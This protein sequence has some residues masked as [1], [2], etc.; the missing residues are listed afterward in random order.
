MISGVVAI[1]GRPNVGKSTIFNRFA[2]ERIS[3]VEDSPGVTRDRIYTTIEWLTRKFNLI[4][5]GGIQLEEDDFQA[6]IFMQV[7]IAIDEADTIVFVVD[8]LSGLTRDDEYIAGLLRKSGKHIILAVNKIDDIEHLNNIYEFY[9]LGLGEPM[10][11]SGEHGVGVGDVLDE[12]VKSLE[13]K[14]IYSKED[15]IKFAVIGRPNVGKST[16]VNKML[17]EQRVIVSD[18]EGTTRDAIDTSFKDEDGNDYVVVD[19]AGIRKRGKVYENIE[20]YSVLRAMTAIDKAD[21]IVFLIDGE[22]GIIEQDKHV[23]GYA[24]DAGKPIL[25][26]YNKWDA[27]ASEEKDIVAM[28]EKIRNEFVYLRYAPIVFI[29]SMTGQR[30]NRILP[31]VKELYENSRRRIQTSVLNEVILDAQ[32]MTPAPI[33]DGRRLRIYYATQVS[34]VPPTFVLFVNDEKLLHFSYK[35]YLENRLREAFIFDGTPIRVIA[36]KRGD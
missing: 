36:R 10:A 20:K 17:N 16:L 27:V 35:R 24:H 33:H 29:S 18:I 11:I 34:I 4:D 6:E 30:V 32:M 2:G 7:E 21:V 13:G 5:T 3:I 1:V 12:V 15:A 8:G 25:I 9:N 19:T 31:L 14:E 23:A 22:V 28:T 26:A